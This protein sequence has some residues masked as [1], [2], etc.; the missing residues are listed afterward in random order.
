[1]K[2][3]S[4]LRLAGA[5]GHEAADKRIDILRRIGGAGSISQ[6]A[7]AAGV[8]YKAAWQAIDTLSNLAGSPLVTSAVG[9]SGGGGASLTPAG[10]QLLLAAD[11]MARAREQVLAR[12]AGPKGS[13][14]QAAGIAALSLRTSMR[15]QLPCKVRT[16]KAAGGMVRIEL[17]LADDEVLAARITRESAQLLALAPGLPV[18]ALCKATGVQVGNAMARTDG[19][20]LLRGSVTRASR[21]AGGGEV[22]LSLEAGLQLVGFAGPG[23]GLKLR[24]PAMA[25]IDE[26]AVVIALAG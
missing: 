4:S 26:T 12:L 14:A 6:A 19:R 20:N 22:A 25:S 9:G 23:H 1:M 18:L 16:M 15:N 8:S 13:A 7:R 24:A 21:A 3:S 5:L 11:E 10:R 17:V 2:T